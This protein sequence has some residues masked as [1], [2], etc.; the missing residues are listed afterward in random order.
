[1]V[2][3]TETE[4]DVNQGNCISGKSPVI[5]CSFV[6]IWM[7]NFILCSTSYWKHSHEGHVEKH[8]QAI[9]GLGRRGYCD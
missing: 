2:K 4:N 6:S 9:Q 1:M 8:P 5:Q 7:A 3:G